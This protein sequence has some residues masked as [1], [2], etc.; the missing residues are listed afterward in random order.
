M[1][2]PLAEKD[3]PAIQGVRFFFDT[4]RQRY[5]LVVAS[6]GR[7]HRSNRGWI[8]E[9]R[10]K[11]STWTSLRL[12]RKPDRQLFWKHRR[13]MFL[14]ITALPKEA[15]AGARRQLARPVGASG[16]PPRPADFQAMAAVLLMVAKWGRPFPE[17]RHEH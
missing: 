3:P 12:A 14:P 15:Q 7:G 5:M 11:T 4:H 1:G 10:E 2:E 9:W 17:D 16:A 8:Y 13:Q 6:R